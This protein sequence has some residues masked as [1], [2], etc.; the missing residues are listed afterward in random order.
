MIAL[1]WGAG[2]NQTGQGFPAQN[3][4]NLGFIENSLTERNFYSGINEA[5][6][7]ERRSEAETRERSEAHRSTSRARVTRMQ[8]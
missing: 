3:S 4:R 1:I 5:S 8:G 7:A 2:S 6:G